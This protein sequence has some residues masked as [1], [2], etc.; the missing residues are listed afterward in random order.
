MNAIANSKQAIQTLLFTGG[1]RTP[2][3][4]G[5]LNRCTSRTSFVGQRKVPLRTIGTRF[6]TL[7]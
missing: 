3:W 5:Y 2:L 1:E 7:C 4:H 6:R